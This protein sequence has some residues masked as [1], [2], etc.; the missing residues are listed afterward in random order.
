M[1]ASTKTSKYAVGFTFASF[2][3]ILVAFVSPYWL[4]T[5]GRLPNP[6]F[7]NLGKLKKH[8]NSILCLGCGFIEFVN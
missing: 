6:K 7:E 2:L 5:D 3:F 4:Q 8:E 1:G